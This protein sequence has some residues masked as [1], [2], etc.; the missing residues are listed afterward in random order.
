MESPHRS[1]FK[2]MDLNDDCLLHLLRFLPL[3]DLNSI[4]L[5]CHRLRA[6][7]DMTYIH[8]RQMKC[9]NVTKMT[10]RYSTNR[11]FNH[12][13]EHINGYLN[14]FGKIIVHIDFENEFGNVNKIF[15]SIVMFCSDELKSLKLYN[16]G[17]KSETILNFRKIF[18]NLTKLELT[19][20]PDL[21]KILP[22]CSNLNTLSIEVIGNYPLILNFKFPMLK[23]FQFDMSAIG[24]IQSIYWHQ[25]T[26][27]Q[28]QMLSLRKFIELNG[29]FCIAGNVVM[30]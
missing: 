19:K 24:L 5:T 7:V 27:L 1:T 2:L 6:L 20:Q 15:A 23:I 16:T 18:S 29:K 25:S 28:Q 13:M 17:L 9:F 11:N 3:T 8:R 22:I 26:L 21:T 12:S 30:N 4:G 10:E 14:K